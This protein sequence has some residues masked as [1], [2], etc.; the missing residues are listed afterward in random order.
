MLPGRK[1][2]TTTHLCLVSAVY[3]SAVIMCSQ[4][5]RWNHLFTNSRHGL[6]P[7]YNTSRPP[8]L[9]LLIGNISGNIRMGTDLLLR[10]L[11]KDW[12]V[13]SLQ[14][15]RWCQ[16]RYQFVTVY[17]DGDFIVLPHWEIKPP[18][19]R[20]DILIKLHY[21]DTEPTSP[22]PILMMLSACLGSDK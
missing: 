5:E 2:P 6:C 21:S 12:N 1:T 16:G 3:L 14:H 7:Q 10:L 18:A 22:C 13:M 9:A 19:P 11:S 20:P 15:L 17:T 4:A 8:A